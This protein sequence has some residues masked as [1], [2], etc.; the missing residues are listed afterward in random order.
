MEHGLQ[1]TDYGLRITG[2]GLLLR[3]ESYSHRIV[4]L[5]DL[6]VADAIIVELKATKDSPDAF[7]AQCLNYL[8]ATGIP[9][10]LLLNFGKPRVEIKRDRRQS[11]FIRV[12]LWP[13]PHEPS[14][15]NKLCNA[16]RQYR[17]LSENPLPLIGQ[18]HFR[19]WAKFTRRKSLFYVRP[20]RLF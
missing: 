12:Y 3:P 2:C 10:C 8:K 13:T 19:N 11:V 16:V 15:R 17:S 18:R 20:N 6:L 1:I 9:L 14:N 5:A 7:A 4:Y